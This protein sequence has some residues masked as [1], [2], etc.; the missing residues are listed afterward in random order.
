VL[1]P[2]GHPAITSGAHTDADVA[3][4]LGAIPQ[5]LAMTLGE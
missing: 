2:P 3:M 4:V 1:W 5:A